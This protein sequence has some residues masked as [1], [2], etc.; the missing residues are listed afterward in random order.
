MKVNAEIAMFFCCRLPKVGTSKGPKLYVM[1]L[2]ICKEI[3][4]VSI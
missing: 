2:I 3:Q 1:D 4:E